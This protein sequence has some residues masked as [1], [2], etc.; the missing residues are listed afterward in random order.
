MVWSSIKNG[1]EGLDL[2]NVKPSR[3][4]VD[5]SENSQGNCGIR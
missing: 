2:V 5:S 1:I 3:L 4:V